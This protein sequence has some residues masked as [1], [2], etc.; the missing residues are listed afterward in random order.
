M[1]VKFLT[2]AR[3]M[4]LLGVHF[5]VPSKEYI[6]SVNRAYRGEAADWEFLNA[7][8]KTVCLELRQSTEVLHGVKTTMYELNCAM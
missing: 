1:P 5:M 3:S 7:L 6:A 8:R 4:E 2:S